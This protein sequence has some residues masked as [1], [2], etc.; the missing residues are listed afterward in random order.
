M[1]KLVRR[2][3]TLV[4]RAFPPGRPY[5]L[6]K[7]LMAAILLIACG[8]KGYELA[9]QPVAGTAILS[10]RPLLIGVTESAFLGLWLLFSLFPSPSGSVQGVLRVLSPRLPGEGPGVLRPL[11]PRLPGEGQGVSGF[12]WLSLLA[13]F[14]LF[15][16]VS[17]H[18]AFLGY[19]T[20][21]CF[22]PLKASP[23]YTALLDVFIVLSLLVLATKG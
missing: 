20:C 15:A 8:L 9:T 22:G 18:K 21:G 7:L 17:F 11:S 3:W 13:L 5:D 10:S 1:K 23:I 4:G 19:A 14:W 6:L 2:L 16:F 12:T